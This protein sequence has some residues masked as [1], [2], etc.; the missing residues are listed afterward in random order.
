MQ[1]TIG[2]V[3][4]TFPDAAPGVAGPQGIQGPYGP[5]IPPG[6]AS[7]GYRTCQFNFTPQVSDITHVNDPT[8]KFSD[9]PY[10]GVR[11]GWTNPALATTVNGALS[12]NNIGAQAG[13][14]AA[15]MQTSVAGSLGHL[16]AANGFYI[17]ARYAISGNDPDHWDAFYLEPQ[18]KCNGALSFGEIDIQE[19]GWGNG[20]MF[21]TIIQWLGPWTAATGYGKGL[22]ESMF[23]APAI[24]RTKPHDYGVS[25][26]PVRKLLIYDCDGVPTFTVDTSQ[27]DPKGNVIDDGIRPYHY[28]AILCP[29]SHGK[30][31]PFSMLVSNM[32]AWTP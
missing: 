2:G 13:Y 28:Y 4:A 25:Y 15:Q 32:Q 9:G 14:I 5:M 24:D 30:A 6:A 10:S 17:S 16:V 27:K 31:V 19:G 7:L 1:V 3:T 29:Q 12:L 8:F 26:N 20:G 18:E 23:T 11:P 21:S 22:Q